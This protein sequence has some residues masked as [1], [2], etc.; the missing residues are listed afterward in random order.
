M[1]DEPPNKQIL[2][3]CKFVR[4]VGGACQSVI[5]LYTTC[6]HTLFKDTT[7]NC[8]ASRS[9]PMSANP[10]HQ[11]SPILSDSDEDAQAVEMLAARHASGVVGE[12]IT[13]TKAAD[14][15]D[16]PPAGKRR[17]VL[18]NYADWDNSS[19]EEELGGGGGDDGSDFSAEAYG[20]QLE[21]SEE[22]EDFSE[23]DLM[24]S[25]PP[26]KGRKPAAKGSTAGA[27]AR[28]ATSKA[29]TS[30][31]APSA[32]S[33]KKTSVAVTK[34]TPVAKPTSVV[35][36]K[37]TGGKAPVAVASKPSTAVTK[38]PS[39]AAAAT[40]TTTKS[41]MALKQ[42]S[43]AVSHAFTPPVRTSASI[44][45]Q[46]TATA[47]TTTA[48]PAARQPFKPVVGGNASSIKLPKGGIPL[49][50]GARV[51]MVGLSRRPQKPAS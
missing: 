45:A 3:S 46:P 11:S 50:G 12:S 18:T 44:P 13:T 10:T 25:P 51:P 2:F 5:L 29:T 23:E 22:E 31:T 7:L 21:D 47:A 36:P 8:I 27:K 38:Q 43:A 49:A 48:A 39:I 16:K 41:H 20:A 28:G 14:A 4:D 33:N 34:P 32:A 15:A 24:D 1:D 35:V 37:P 17:R 26:R 19:E 6:R 42:P 9:S 30:K 40:N